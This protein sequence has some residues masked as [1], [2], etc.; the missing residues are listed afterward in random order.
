M[1]LPRRVND[2]PGSADA[3]DNISGFISEMPHQ[4]R[5]REL[6][7]LA[8]SPD[9]SVGSIWFGSGAFFLAGLLFSWILAEGHRRRAVGISTLGVHLYK[10]LNLILWDE[11]KEVRPLR[12]LHIRSLRLIRESGEIIIMPWTSSGNDIPT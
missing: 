5:F 10:G 4:A 1:P 6:S 7:D 9:C 3:E 11:I 12:I 8:G 2:E